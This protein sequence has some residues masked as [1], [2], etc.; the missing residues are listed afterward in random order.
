MII[1]HSILRL[2]ALTSLFRIAISFTVNSN[3]GNREEEIAGW[4]EE[5]V[6]LYDRA[7]KVLES[8]LTPSIKNILHTCLGRS[9][10]EEDFN[11]IKG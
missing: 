4:V 9:A 6:F 7:A 3:C 10:E 8:P 2:I 11:A 1:F 5:A